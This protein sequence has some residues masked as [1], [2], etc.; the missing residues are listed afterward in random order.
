MD[1]KETVHKQ[2]AIAT[3]EKQYVLSG[4]LLIPTL[5]HGDSSD[6]TAELTK[7]MIFKVRVC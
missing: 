2:F 6:Q 3:T 5:Y 1:N 7:M 4:R